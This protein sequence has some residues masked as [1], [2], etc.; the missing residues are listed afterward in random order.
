MET[1]RELT[2][3]IQLQSWT[4]FAQTRGQANVNPD[5]SVT[6]VNRYFKLSLFTLSAGVHAVNLGF[7]LSITLRDVTPRPPNVFTLRSRRLP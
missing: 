5:A 2:T 4:Q 1:I 6:H 3:A 7:L